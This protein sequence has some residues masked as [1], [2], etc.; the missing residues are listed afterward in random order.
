[1]SS[2][3]FPRLQVCLWVRSD[4]FLQCLR[5]LFSLRVSIDMTNH[6]SPS[7]MD[8]LA[9]V[10]GENRAS[11]HTLLHPA[12]HIRRPEL[13]PGQSPERDSHGAR[14]WSEFDSSVR[15][16]VSCH[17]CCCVSK[18]ITNNH[19]HSNLFLATVFLFPVVSYLCTPVPCSDY[20]SRIFLDYLGYR[21]DPRYIREGGL[22]RQRQ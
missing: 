6:M 10:I 1:M 7:C 5:L 22:N 16:T 2:F 21:V 18:G 19:F 17:L 12:S 15:Q 13:T 11:I 8:T 4:S 3:L 14:G 20:T 9:Q